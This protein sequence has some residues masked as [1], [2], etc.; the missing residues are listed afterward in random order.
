MPVFFSQAGQVKFD[1]LNSRHEFQQYH[2]RLGAGVCDRGLRVVILLSSFFARSALGTAAAQKPFTDR[3][4][5]KTPDSFVER[6]DEEG[7]RKR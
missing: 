5:G 4:Q 3:Q 1:A 7:L 6:E 2:S